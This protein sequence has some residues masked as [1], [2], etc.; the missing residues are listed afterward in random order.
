VPV[1]LATDD[2]VHCRGFDAAEVFRTPVVGSQAQ[3]DQAAE[4]AGLAEYLA[5]EVR[6]HPE[7]AAA[8]ASA[9]R[10]WSG[11]D[12]VLVGAARMAVADAMGTVRSEALALLRG[13]P[14]V[15]P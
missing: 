4:L 11:G 6:G 1:Q 15:V 14:T 13:A 5:V 8:A 3:R 7:N 9:L 10:E 2:E 12:L